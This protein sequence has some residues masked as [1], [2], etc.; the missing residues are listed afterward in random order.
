M[1]NPANDWDGYDMGW[2]VIRKADLIEYLQAS[3]ALLRDYRPAST[4]SLYATCDALAA[5]SCV[6]DATTFLRALG[7]P[8][9]D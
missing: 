4:G 1:T 8:D 2:G 3:R 7:V 5:S 9:D 6:H